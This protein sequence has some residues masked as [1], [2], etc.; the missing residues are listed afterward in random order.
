[1]AV[2]L[3]TDRSKKS[4]LI[5]LSGGVD[6]AVAAYLLKELGYKVHAITYIL[7]D[8]QI[9]SANDASAIA[10]ILDI[11]LYIEDRR[12]EFNETIVKYFTDSYI[13]GDTPNPCVLCNST[14]KFKH[15][16]DK[17]ESLGIDLVATGH[18]AN[19]EF[20]KVT[21]RYI[22]K[23]SNNSK[24]DQ[25]YFLY[26]LTQQQL[27]K[28]LL[29]ISDMNKEDVRKVAD[30]IGLSVKDKKDSQDICFIKGVNY[31]EFIKSRDEN[32]YNDCT[33]TDRFGNLLGKGANHIHFTPGQ[34][35]GLNKGF[36]Q[37]MYVIS[38]DAEK[39]TV[40]LGNEDELYKKELVLNDINLIYLD[41]ITEPLRVKVKIRNSM[42]AVDALVMMA[43]KR[44][45]IN[46]DNPVRAAAKGQSAVFYEND[47]VVGGGIIYDSL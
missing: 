6:S 46:F 45:K 29:P 18:Y 17:A 1:M 40:I 10:Q 15:L 19:I 33:F 12:Q 26:R 4:V 34:R 7:S 11:P 44:V 47:R 43:D 30:K 31:T 35:R 22:L 3:V 2:L 38:K 13:N 8:N 37:R 23:K 24:K 36:N 25:S 9:S 5:G 28:M 42:T 16:I 41:K 20:D 27:S 32:S 21:Q 14:F 39:N